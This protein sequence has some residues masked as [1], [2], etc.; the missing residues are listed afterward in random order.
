MLAAADQHDVRLVAGA[1]ERHGSSNSRACAG[2]GHDP[3]GELV[4]GGNVITWLEHGGSPVRA[5]KGVRA[6]G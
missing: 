6:D 3:A 4:G 2:D 1:G 5:L